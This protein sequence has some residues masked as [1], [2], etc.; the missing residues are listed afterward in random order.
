MIAAGTH[1]DGL[2]LRR[3]GVDLISLA[4]VGAIP[5]VVVLAAGGANGPGVGWLSLSSYGLSWRAPESSSFGSPQLFSEDGTYLLE[6]G[7]DAG[8][9]VRVQVYTDYLPATADAL[10]YLEDRYNDLGPAD[11]AAAQAS[12]GQTVDTGYQLANVTPM[13]IVGIK[14]WIDPAVSSLSVSSDGIT[15]YTP[16]SES[17]PHVLSWSIVGAGGSV[18]VYVRRTIGAGAGPDPKVLNA[19]HFSWTGF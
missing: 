15:Y 9:W 1:G 10:V 2:R 4:V 8:K 16:T 5:G 18:N 6:D 14:L 17:D 3:T 12:A 11:V 13:T 19:L 7:E